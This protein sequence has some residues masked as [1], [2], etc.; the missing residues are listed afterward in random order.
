MP[1]TRAERRKPSAGCRLC[2]RCWRPRVCLPCEAKDVL[3][4]VWMPVV[5]AEARA[6]SRIRTRRRRGMGRSQD[7]TERLREVLKKMLVISRTQ[8][9]TEVAQDLSLN[10]TILSLTR[11]TKCRTH[12]AKMAVY[13]KLGYFLK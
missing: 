6:R 1:P 4:D 11:E 9:S 7:A 12:R 2:C 13:R 10:H 3:D 5:C 8:R